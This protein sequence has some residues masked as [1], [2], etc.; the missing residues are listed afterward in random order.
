MGVWASPTWIYTATRIN[1]LL[2]MLNN[3][4]A[5]VREHARASLLL[6]LTKRKVPRSTTGPNFLGFRK[7]PSG[8]LDTR[9]PGL[10]KIM[11]KGR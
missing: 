3:D 9:A 1:H 2:R 5:A 11:L 6:D 7:K 4:D 10:D 8:K